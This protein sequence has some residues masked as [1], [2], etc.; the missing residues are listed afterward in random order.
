MC[1]WFSLVSSSVFQLERLRNSASRLFV[2]TVRDRHDA[3]FVDQRAVECDCSNLRQCFVF[4]AGAD[5]LI[6]DP[7]DCR[8]SPNGE[9]TTLNSN[10]PGFINCNLLTANF[11]IQ[12][13]RQAHFL[14]AVSS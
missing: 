4:D 14:N 9:W 2:F 7:N 8:K 11:N 12:N 1:E 13:L 3:A 10:A 5:D 6:I